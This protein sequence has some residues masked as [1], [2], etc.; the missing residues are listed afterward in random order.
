MRKKMR[1]STVVILTVMI[2]VCGWMLLRRMDERI[3]ILKNN[4]AIADQ[5]VLQ[6]QNEQSNMITELARKD[7]ESYLIEQARE[8]GYVMQDEIRFVVM[9]PEVLYEQEQTEEETP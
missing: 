5:E 4:K 8:Q 2:V 6:I 1:I 9:N 3:Q 7:T